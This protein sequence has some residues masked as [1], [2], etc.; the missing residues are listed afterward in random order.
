MTRHRAGILLVLVSTVPF[1]LAG[2]FTRT[3]AAG[4]WEVLAWRG[5]I[6][7]GAILAYAFWRE[8]RG[9]FG[10]RGWLLALVGAAASLAF[11]AAFRMTH[12]A[13]VALIYAMAP[14]VAA[15]LD[16]V[17]R[18]QPV[19]PALMR[20]AGLSVAG[21][22]VIVAGGLGAARLGGDAVALLM[23]VLFASYTVMVRAFGEVPVMRAGAVS[24]LIL[25]AA[26]LAFGRPFAVGWAEAPGLAGFGLSFALAVILF[27]EGARRVAP[28]EA[29]FYGGAEVPLAVALAWALLGEVP[30][31]ATWLGGA[32]VAGA[33]LWRGW[34]DLKDGRPGAG[35]SSSAR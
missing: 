35:L 4:L 10:W 27:T 34:R 7:G 20:S 14:F 29:G 22:A 16:R 31:V 19:R 12:V 33:V 3:I 13:N 2:V 8:G 24:A 9:P 5:L 15:G 6:G 28:A 18:G 25:F 17:F 21:V 30:P 26:G 1:A 32:L 23:V 11:L